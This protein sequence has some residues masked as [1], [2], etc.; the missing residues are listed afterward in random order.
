MR[1]FLYIL[2]LIACTLPTQ[3]ALGQ[4]DI[5]GA[6][7][8]A[9]SAYAS[10]DL[11]D[12]RFKLQ[13]A[14]EEID[15]TIALKI[16]EMLPTQMR[17]MQATSADEYTGNV[18]GFTGLYVNRTYS[19][20]SDAQKSVTIT[21]LNDSPLMAG[22]NAFLNNPVIG[23]ITGMGRKRI[24]VDGYKGSMQQDEN[25]PAVYDINIPFGQSLLTVQVQG[26][27]D[28]NKVLAMVN[29]LPVVNIAHV[30]Q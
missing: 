9:Q 2:S 29:T 11:D 28:E 14:L 3:W 10:G 5:V 21:L 19:H 6:I 22:V 1:K 18:T 26:E 15:K 13:Q 20:P 12:T 8:A 27:T 17:D 23:G 4:A 7:S 16:L 24:R 25:N 30:A